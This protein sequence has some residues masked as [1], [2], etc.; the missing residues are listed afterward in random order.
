MGKISQGFAL[1]VMASVAT[2]V[3][4]LLSFESCEGCE[5]QGFTPDANGIYLAHNDSAC[6]NLHYH[7]QPHSVHGGETGH[8]SDCYQI[9]IAGSWDD[10]SYLHHLQVM[11]IRNGSSYDMGRWHMYTYWV[12]Y[13]TYC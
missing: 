9:C 6:N 3:D 2:A 13:W 12:G 5:A 4:V 7:A 11:D 8:S 1:S 10:Y